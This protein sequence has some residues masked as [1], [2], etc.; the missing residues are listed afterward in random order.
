M[1]RT[2]WGCRSRCVHLLLVLVTSVM[3]MPAA[4]SAQLDQ[5]RL[6]GTVTDAQGAV[7]PGVTVTAT[8]PS[9]IGT[10]TAVSEENGTYRFPALASGLYAL[11]F[12]L[13]GFRTVKREN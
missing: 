5:G 2:T 7:L 11:T 12:E 4:A 6:T 13:T 10:Q 1:G 9:L 3:M 8:S